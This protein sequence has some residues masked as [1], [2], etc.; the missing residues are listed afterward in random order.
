MSLLYLSDTRIKHP[1]VVL[2]RGNLLRILAGSI[3]N[4]RLD[5][6]LSVKDRHKEPTR[7]VTLHDPLTVRHIAPHL[8]TIHGVERHRLPLREVVKRDTR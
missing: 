8:N 5:L 6:S 4:V 7:E 2:K 3:V 1:W